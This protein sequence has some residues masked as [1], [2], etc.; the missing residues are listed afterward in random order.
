[1]GR[2]VC[3]NKAYVSSLPKTL[4]DCHSSKGYIG[5]PQAERG[6]NLST[7]LSAF[8]QDRHI[9]FQALSV[10]L[11]SHSD[12]HLRDAADVVSFFHPPPSS[13]RF[14]GTLGMYRR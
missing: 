14:D 3:G 1:M 10:T 12:P 2:T 9:A 8:E 7:T 11:R 6:S 5:T 13:G 4:R